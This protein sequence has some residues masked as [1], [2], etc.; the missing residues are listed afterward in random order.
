MDVYLAPSKAQGTAWF[1]NLVTQ[2]I[3]AKFAQL[4]RMFLS[5]VGH[6]HPIAKIVLFTASCQPGSLGVRRGLEEV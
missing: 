6:S 4:G 1:G 3:L 5:E 2:N